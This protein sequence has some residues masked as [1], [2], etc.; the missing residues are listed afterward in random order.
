LRTN[1]DKRK[2]TIIQALYRQNYN[3]P[4]T[5]VAS[6]KNFILVSMHIHNLRNIL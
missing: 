4:R 1:A 6:H 3:K 2:Q 5:V